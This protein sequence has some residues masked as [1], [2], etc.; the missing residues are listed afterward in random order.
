MSS[1]QRAGTKTVLWPNVDFLSPLMSWPN[2]LQLIE[3]G[4]ENKRGKTLNHVPFD[5]DWMTPML[6]YEILSTM[7]R[8]TLQC[9]SWTTKTP[10]KVFNFSKTAQLLCHRWIRSLSY[11]GMSPPIPN[12]LASRN[13]P[14]GQS[15]RQGQMERHF[16]RLR[17]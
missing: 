3:R 6:P 13:T 9:R 14:F 1:F 11:P 2:V 15:P 17:R 16:P 10:F 8:P 4:G 5:L 12:R 7:G